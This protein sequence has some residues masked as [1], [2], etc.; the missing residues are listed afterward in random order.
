MSFIVGLDVGQAA[1]YTALGVI[2]RECRPTG[3][4]DPERGE[5]FD[6][7]YTVIH[8][9]RPALKTPYPEIIREVKK[10]L[11]HPRLLGNSELVVDA[12]GVGRPVVDMLR[13]AGC[14]PRPVTITG[15]QQVNVG[16]DG[17]WHV[18]KRVLVSALAIALQ[19]GRLHIRS[20]L[21]LAEVLSREMLAFKVKINAHAN[22][23]YEAWR[24]GDHDDLVLS[25]A[26]AVWWGE[27]NAQG[28]W[29]GGYIDAKERRRRAFLEKQDRPWWKQANPSDRG[30]NAHWKKT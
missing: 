20:K 26:L 25:V 14:E 12:T 3:R 28:G 5:A 18:P 10:T 9:E 24:E 29:R 11:R 17:Y 6:D 30:D 22:E 19:T 15:G 2:E 21:A 16:P 7:H 23:S 1:D 13:E 4:K 8:M 27:R